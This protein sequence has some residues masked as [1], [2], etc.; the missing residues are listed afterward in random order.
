MLLT[1]PSAK[2]RGTLGCL[3]LVIRC[4][5]F[6]YKQLRTNNQ[7]KMLVE[8]LRKKTLSL[9]DYPCIT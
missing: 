7:S 1:H 4:L 9:P 8:D 2:R 5:Y 6:F 3:L